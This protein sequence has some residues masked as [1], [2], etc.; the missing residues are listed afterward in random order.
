MPNRR[1]SSEEV[2]RSL[3][4]LRFTRPK[5]VGLARTKPFRALN[6]RLRSLRL[7][8]RLIAAE[9]RR[10]FLARSCVITRRIALDHSRRLVIVRRHW[11][12]SRHATRRKLV[13]HKNVEERDGNGSTEDI[14]FSHQC[15]HSHQP[16]KC[17]SAT[18]D[19]RQPSP[20][21]PGGSL[22]SPL[23]MDQFG[24]GSPYRTPSHTPSHAN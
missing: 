24:S 17:V 19:Y 6:G 10:A 18:H 8:G 9:F 3:E 23:N 16:E 13:G 7:R 22:H 2:R 14:H 20:Y 15:M 11:P 21:L 12:G 4:G 1:G 5:A